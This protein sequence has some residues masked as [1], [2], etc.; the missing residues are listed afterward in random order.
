MRL[1][2]VSWMWIVVLAICAYESSSVRADVP[3]IGQAQAEQLGL[4]RSWFLQVPM[5]VARSKISHIKVQAGLVLVVTDEGMLHVID[6]ETGHLQWSFRVGRAKYLATGAYANSSHVAV[7]NIETV[8]VL[9]RASGN[10]VYERALTGTPSAMGPGLTRDYVMVPL[11]K[12]PL[13][14]YPLPRPK[15]SE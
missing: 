1:R 14:T 6:A 5:D 2:I 8:Y 10:L 4:K 13:E 9:D 3:L 7:A 15:M 11:V 12:G